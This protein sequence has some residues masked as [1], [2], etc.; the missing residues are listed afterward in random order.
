MNKYE[1]I[2]YPHYNRGEKGTYIHEYTD[3]REMYY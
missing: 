2:Y 1:T 3:K